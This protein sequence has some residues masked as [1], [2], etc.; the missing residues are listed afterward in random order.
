MAAVYTVRFYAGNLDSDGAHTLFTV[1]SGYIW[2]LREIDALCHSAGSNSLFIERVDGL[3]ITGVID[4]TTNVANQWT[5]RCV[6]EPGE[7]FEAYIGAGNWDLYLSG[8][9]LSLP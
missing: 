2:V 9:Q 7:E 5:G 1:P 6:L 3:T 4:P 8:Y